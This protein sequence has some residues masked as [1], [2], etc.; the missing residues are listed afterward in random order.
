[1]VFPCSLSNSKSLQVSTTLL[2]IPADPNIAVVWTIS[3]RLVISKSSSLCT[4]HL[5]TVPRAPITIGTI[6]TFMFRIFFNYQQGRS[7]YPSLGILSILLFRPLRQQSPQFCKF[8]FVLLII[9]G[10]GRLVNLVIHLYM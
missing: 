8:S 4:N 3:A 10:S 9:I 7:T 1:M 5:L 2:S 6:V